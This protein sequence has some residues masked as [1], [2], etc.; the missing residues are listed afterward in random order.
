MLM[1]HLSAKNGTRKVIEQK[2]LESTLHGTSAIVGIIAFGSDEAH[3]IVGDMEGDALFFKTVG[4]APNLQPDNLLNLTAFQGGEHEDIVN[5]VDKLRPQSGD[6]GTGRR[7]AGLGEGSH[8]AFASGFAAV[9]H[10]LGIFTGEEV[11]GHDDNRVLEIDRA[12]LI[13]GQAA[14][15]KHL[16]E[17]V[18]HIGVRLFDFVEEHD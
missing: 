14:V 12:T 18:E 8:Q 5:A 11:G 16:Q 3:G 1:S 2:A 15:V 7:D 9:A 10:S 4:D 13:V 17:D 6:G